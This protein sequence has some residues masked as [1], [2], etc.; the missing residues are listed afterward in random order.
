LSQLGERDFPH[1]DT[2]QLP[3]GAECAEQAGVLLVAGEDL[4][5]LLEH[6]PGNNVGHP[7]G[8]AGRERY[9]ERLAAERAS[10]DGAET[11]G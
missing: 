8:R 5:P 10:V 9:I 4:V 11:I 1:R 7:F 6:Q 3:C 2:F